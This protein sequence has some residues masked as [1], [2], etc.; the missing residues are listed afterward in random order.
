M[1]LGRQPS[2][3]E[4]GE[5]MEKTQ[6][7][8]D[9]MISEIS[10]FNVISLEEEIADNFKMQI[11]DENNVTPEDALMKKAVIE[12]LKNAVAKLNEK[13]QAVID[14]YYNKELTYKE[15]GEVLDVSESRI[16][17]I[18]SKAITKM[19]NYIK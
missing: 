9:K 17:Q 6:E 4:I 7:E 8:M 13:E 5:K 3:K 15:I 11:K 19:R 16:S 1:E 14:L 2:I 10:I 18:H 12:S